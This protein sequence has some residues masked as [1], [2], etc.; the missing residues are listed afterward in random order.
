MKVSVWDE[1]KRIGAEDI[2]VKDD[3]HGSFKW[4]EQLFHFM[5]D[6]TGFLFVEDREP[7]PFERKCFLKAFNY[8]SW[9]IENY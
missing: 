3:C 2:V 1:V 9:C 7:V 5:I 6:E 4:C 8:P